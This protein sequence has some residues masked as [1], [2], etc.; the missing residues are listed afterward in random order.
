MLEELMNRA[1]PTCRASLET[2][3][4][5]GTDVSEECKL[6]FQEISMEM[7]RE[8]EGGRKSS[9]KEA[10]KPESWI[11]PAIVVAIFVGAAFAAVAGYVVHVNSQLAERERGKSR[12]QKVG[13]AFHDA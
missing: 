2:A 3:M 4:Q 5:S 8:F 13:C 6:E 9:G 11:H 7:R 1:T 12:K 10:P